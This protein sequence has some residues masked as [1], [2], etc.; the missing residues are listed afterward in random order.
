M[1]THSREIICAILKDRECS[2][3]AQQREPAALL[4][5]RHLYPWSQVMVWLITKFLDKPISRP[6]LWAMNLQCTACDWKTT[7]DGPY[8]RRDAM[9]PPMQCLEC[10]SPVILVVPDCPY[11][12]DNLLPDDPASESQLRSMFRL[13]RVP[14]SLAQGL[15]GHFTCNECDRVFDKWGRKTDER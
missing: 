13:F 9:S 6:D 5:Q 15:W 1:G 2:C 8:R 3:R 12:G 7:P 14:R 11:C 4:L 10:K